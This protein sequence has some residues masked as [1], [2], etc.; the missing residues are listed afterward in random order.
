MRHGNVLNRNYCR[1]KVVKS[2]TWCS[3]RVKRLQSISQG[4]L[5]PT[6]GLIEAG[7]CQLA[8]VWAGLIKPHCTDCVCVCV[9]VCVWIQKRAS[10]SSKYLT[11]GNKHRLNSHS[12]QR[13]TL[14]FTLSI[15]AA[16]YS[17]MWVFVSAFIINER[18]CVWVCVCVLGGRAAVR[19]TSPASRSRRTA[20]VTGRLAPRRLTGS[21]LTAVQSLIKCR[22]VRENTVF[23]CFCS[24]RRERRGGGDGDM[25]LFCWFSLISLVH[26]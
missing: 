4:P 26:C 21:D 25:S 24:C 8:V 6:D 16:C 23:R 13:H 19:L 20:A 11:C 7:L 17:N 3:T 2:R 5:A 12:A 10:M 15:Y 1:G 14:R 22:V 18:V 9:C